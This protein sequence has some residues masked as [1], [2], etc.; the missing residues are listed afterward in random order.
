MVDGGVGIVEIEEIG[1]IVGIVEI[2]WDVNVLVKRQVK[3]LGM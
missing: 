1:G 2:G 3:K